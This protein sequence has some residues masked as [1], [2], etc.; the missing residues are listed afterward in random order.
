VSRPVSDPSIRSDGMTIDTEFGPVDPV[1]VDRALRG[2]PVRLR[3]TDSR[4]LNLQLSGD[5]D[6]A[7]RVADA[8]GVSLTSILRRIYRRTAADKE[9]APT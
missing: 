9:G 6:E 5:W 4:Y 8:L 7:A 3:P 1:A 2:Y